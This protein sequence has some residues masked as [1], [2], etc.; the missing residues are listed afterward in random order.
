ME[1]N[2]KPKETEKNV[3]PSRTLKQE[4]WTIKEI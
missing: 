1:K 4:T 3:S 2:P